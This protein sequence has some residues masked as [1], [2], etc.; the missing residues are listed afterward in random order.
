MVTIMCVSAVCIPRV[1]DIFM[2]CRQ[3]ASITQSR[4]AASAAI[5]C[6]VK[7]EYHLIHEVIVSLVIRGVRQG[8]TAVLEN[9]FCSTTRKCVSIMH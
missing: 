5:D 8:H 4:E 9:H 3:P 2:I 6:T 7:G 1:Y